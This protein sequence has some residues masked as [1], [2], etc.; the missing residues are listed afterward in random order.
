LINNDNQLIVLKEEVKKVDIVYAEDTATIG[1]AREIA[2][3]E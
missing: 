1:S 3:I 2:K